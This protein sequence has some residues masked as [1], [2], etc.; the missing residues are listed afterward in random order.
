MLQIDVLIQQIKGTSL[1]EWLAVIFGL[2][3][4]IFARKNNPL[5]YPSGIVST[6]IYS[7]LW[8]QQEAGLYAEAVLN[9]YYLIMSI[10]GWYCWMFSSKLKY[11]TLPISKINSKGLIQCII[12]F[13]I[14]WGI[15]FFMLYHTNSTVPIWDSL[16][17][18]LA[19]VGMWLL[20]KRKIENWIFLNLSNLISI[21]LFCYKGYILTAIFTV[22]LFTIACFGYWNW[23]QI[24][25]LQTI[26]KPI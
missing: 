24:Y 7:Y 15:V 26:N 11:Q 17:A 25:K 4:V 16:V 9:V 12:R 2:I 23:K 1:L 3:S 22:I 8:M 21:P 19:C 5:L 18:G 13:L 14:I 20:A 10:Y 6:S